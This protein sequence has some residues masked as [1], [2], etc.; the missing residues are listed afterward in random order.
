MDALGQGLPKKMFG[1]E[2]ED[3]IRGAQAQLKETNPTESFFGS[4]GASAVPSVITGGVGM[5]R[6]GATMAPTMLSNARTAIFE[7][8]VQGG[9][10]SV[11]ESRSRDPLELLQEAGKGGAFGGVTGGG[12]SMV[13]DVGSAGVRNMAARLTKGGT[14][15]DAQRELIKAL[16]RDTKYGSTE[17]PALTG[18]TRLQQLP[19]E[20]RLVDVG[21][22]STRQLADILATLPGRAANEMEEAIVERQANRANR[23][24]TAADVALGSRG[25]QYLDTLGDLEAKQVA[26][27][28]PLY[29]QLKN[30]QVQADDD[31]LSLLRRAGKESLTKSQRLSRLAGEDQVS[32]SEAL[33]EARDAVTNA[34]IP[35]RPITFT[36]LDHVKQALYDLESKFKKSGE[37][38]EASAFGNLRRELTAKLDQLSP[39]DKANQS[40]YAQARNAYAGPA[41]AQDAVEAGRDVFK[42]KPVELKQVMDELG[43]GQMEHFRIGVLQGIREKTGDVAGQTKL[44]NMWRE[45]N[46]S[47]RLKMV[48]GNNFDDFAQA[49]KNENTLKLFETVGRGA[50]TAGRL[51]QAE[52]LGANLVQAAEDVASAKAGNPI[53]VISRVSKQFNKVAL[54]ESTRNQLAL[55]LLQRGGDAETTLKT[56]DQVIRNM[57]KRSQLK[58]SLSGSAGATSQ[59]RVRNK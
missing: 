8:G 25:Q 21:G 24:L 18:I 15:S 9:A 32:V 7:G 55:M 36:S 56:L 43:A 10:Q 57:N 12:F 13:G 2:A 30:V 44:L 47:D 37:L 28:K 4:L 59:Q 3:Y 40:I 19:P 42:L 5:L 51:A 14:M 11:G 38:Q 46:T 17:S 27:A 50:Q 16:Q 29:D 53:G 33:K 26:Q 31:L 6:K 58:S 52:D 23:L 48:F 20:A 54:P 34:A 1:Q 45:P 41:Q 39:T 22:K 35:G 49:V